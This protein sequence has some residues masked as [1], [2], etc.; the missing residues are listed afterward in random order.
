MGNSKGTVLITGCSDG[1][2]GAALAKAFHSRGF[3]VIATTRSARRAASL[4]SLGLQ[5]LEL[6]ITSPDSIKNCVAEVSTLTNGTLDILINNAGYG[7]TMPITDTSTAAARDLFDTNFFGALSVI[8]AFLPLLMTAANSSSNPPMIVNN[9]SIVGVIPIPFQGVYNASKAALASL[10][11][12]LRLE[13]QGFNI[14]LV[15]LKTGAVASEFFNNINK[16]HEGKSFQHHPITFSNPNS[17]APPILNLRTSSQRPRLPLLPHR[18]P[19]DRYLPYRLRRKGRF[20]S[21]V[22]QV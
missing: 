3:Q 5:V 21:P 12:T 15:D 7:L 14:N 4:K 9:T 10:T 16:G 2:I 1:G 22:E 11:D 19:Q 8:Q 20:R 17:S 13:L 18:N 6:D